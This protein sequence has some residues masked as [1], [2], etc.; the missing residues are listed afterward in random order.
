ME[1]TLETLELQGHPWH[2]PP[3]EVAASNPNVSEN[4][5]L[6]SAKFQG[7]MAPLSWN[8]SSLS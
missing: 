1:E 6:S 4:G 5:A 3:R 8:Q 7:Q 2:T